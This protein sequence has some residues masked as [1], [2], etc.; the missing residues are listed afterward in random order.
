M[1]TLAEVAVAAL[2]AE[3]RKLKSQWEGELASEG[4]EEL[5]LAGVSEAEAGLGSFSAGGSDT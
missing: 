4:W 5:N 2:S 1:Q 3:D